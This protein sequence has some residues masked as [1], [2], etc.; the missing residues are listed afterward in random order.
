[1]IY[2]AVVCIVISIWMSV[3]NIQTRS[4]STTMFIISGLLLSFGIMFGLIYLASLTE[5]YWFSPI[6]N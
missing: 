5:G 1:M 3:E 4:N 2:I 6:N